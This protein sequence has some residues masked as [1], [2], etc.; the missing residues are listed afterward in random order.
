MIT[1][2]SLSTAP[3][4]PFISYKASPYTPFIQRARTLYP[5][6]G[7]REIHAFRVGGFW[8]W[9]GWRMF[10]FWL[11]KKVDEYASLFIVRPLLCLSKIS[12]RSDERNSSQIDIPIGV[13]FS[14]LWLWPITTSDFP[15]S[16][17]LLFSDHPFWDL[18]LEW[19]LHDHSPLFVFFLVCP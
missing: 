11:E 16:N 8:S 1:Y 17:S 5:T 6:S 18:M 12:R 4:A 15:N 2:H 19:S 13:L 9:K 14:R 10:L 3:L 7:G